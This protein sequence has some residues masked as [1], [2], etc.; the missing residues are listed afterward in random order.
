MRLK[1]G[2]EKPQ[3]VKLTD[4]AEAELLNSAKPTTL[5]DVKE[6]NQLAKYQL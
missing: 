5:Y 2:V 6:I 3:D 1:V 4:A